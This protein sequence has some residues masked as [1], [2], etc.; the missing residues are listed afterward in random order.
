MAAIVGAPISAVAYLYLAAANRLQKWLYASL[1]GELGF[2]S[3]PAWWPFPLLIIGGLLVAVVVTY[4][5]GTGGHKPLEGLKVGG[6]APAAELPGIA[7]AALVTLGCGAVLGP[8]APL[9][10]LG[11]GLCAWAVSHAL[12]GDK[13]QAVLI[14]A[15]AGSFAAIST[16]L[17]N[18][19]VGAFVLM[20]A[21]GLSSSM[22]ELVLLPGLLAAGIGA[23][24]FTG[25][26]SW[27][28]LGTFS[29]GL[30]GLPSFGRPDIAE[31]GWA[32]LVG[33]AAAAAVAL[34]RRLAL[35]LRP[36][37]EHR[38]MIVTPLAGLVVAGLAVLFSQVTGKTT[39]YVLFSGQN[40]LAPFVSHRAE[41]GLAAVCL[42]LLCKSLAYSVSLP[43]FRGG[44]IF[45]SIFLG[46]AAGVA[47]GHLPGLP[48][49]AAMGMGIG[50]MMAAM[51]RLPLSGALL[52]VLL[53]GS[54]GVAAT[55]LVIVA[56]V[57]AFVAAEHL[58]PR[59]AATQPQPAPSAGAQSST[60][61][62][63]GS[64]ASS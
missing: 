59:D 20:E 4:L 60:A 47:L 63:P 54:D 61:L 50:A 17:G 15:A 35:A 12:K 19:L 43:T 28:G 29:L 45:P 52:A 51:L 37:A 9:I 48:A 10:A 38:M 14:L 33:L 42:L 25:L 3:V 36:H 16:M 26:D 44:P 46:A 40:E 5:P 64:S 56:V 13:P 11:G 62:A 49:V 41:I 34:I 27:T 8:E 21:A 31:F 18:P 6:V 23:L 22:L 53:L 7:L 24:V 55:P 1:P 32:I 58:D 30:P 2:K 57:V 39:A